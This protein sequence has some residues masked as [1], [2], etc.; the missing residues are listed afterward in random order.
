MSISSRIYI[1]SILVIFLVII[2]T[3]KI[4][5]SLEVNSYISF[6]ATLSSLILAVFAIFLTLTGNSELAKFTASVASTNESLQLSAKKLAD[7]SNKSA[8]NSNSLEIEL[9]KLSNLVSGI[10]GKFDARF[11]KLSD[12]AKT[13][14]S[15]QAPHGEKS[16]AADTSFSKKDFLRICSPAGI[17]LLLYLLKR[18]QIKKSYNV[19]Y[20]V[21]ILQVSSDYITG[22]IA[23]CNSTGIFKTRTTDGKTKIYEMVF[24]EHELQEAVKRKIKIFDDTGKESLAKKIQ[25]IFDSVLLSS[26]EEDDELIPDSVEEEKSENE[27]LS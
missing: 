6:A 27:K 17:M 10:E 2:S 22:F 24:S 21:K 11:D 4:G 23:P 8:M 15:T 12:Q 14:Y 19:K 1:A 26:E 25:K 20:M 9:G 13:L 3:A 18:Q 16:S 7:N 5:S